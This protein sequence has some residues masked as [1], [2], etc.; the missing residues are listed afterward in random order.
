MAGATAGEVTVRNL[1]PLSLQADT[2]ICTALERAGA[3]LVSEADSVTA[4]RRE[5]RA[6]RFDATQCPDLFPALVALAAAAEGVSVI[7]GAGRLHSKE[8]DRADTLQEEYARLG[9]AIDLPD[10]NRMLVRGGAI[11]P[12]EVWSHGDHRI[13]MSL[14]VAALRCTGG[15]VTLRD[16]EV[17]SKSY[18]GFYEALDALRIQA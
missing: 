18:P 11:R 17:V 8:C 16:A 9:I 10:E 4:L 13:A 6:F 2:A 3:G 14:A 5:L 15:S 7:E 12:A 1:S